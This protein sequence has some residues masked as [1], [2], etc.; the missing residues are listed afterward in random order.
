M[1]SLI[2]LIYLIPE[3]L[4]LREVLFEKKDVLKN[5]DLSFLGWKLV[6]YTFGALLFG[7]IL[8]GWYKERKKGREDE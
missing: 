6:I 1:I 2:Y 8:L 5:G 4:V 3:F 7:T